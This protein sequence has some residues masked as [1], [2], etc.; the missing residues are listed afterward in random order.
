MSTIN[1]E[2]ASA[3]AST[4]EVVSGVGYVE[5]RGLFI[6]EENEGG[7]SSICLNLPGVQSQGETLNEAIQN[8]KE[9]F[10]LAVET[11]KESGEEI[12]WR[13]LSNEFPRECG[14]QRW[15]TVHV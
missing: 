3:V 5:C 7:Y 12:P 4:P 9:A 13:D 1:V 8:L 11:Y 10:L 6:K 14:E 15:F 2:P